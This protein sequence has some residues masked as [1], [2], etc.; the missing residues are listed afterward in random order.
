MSLMAHPKT[1]YL[2]E[3]LHWFVCDC[4]NSLKMPT[5][6]VVSFLMVLVI[7]LLAGN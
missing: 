6:G 3:L 2:L 7:E 4:I 1:L 5:S